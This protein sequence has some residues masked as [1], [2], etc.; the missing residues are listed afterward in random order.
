MIGH[1]VKM[2]ISGSEIEFFTFSDSNSNAVFDLS[3]I[4]LSPGKYI[5]TFTDQNYSRSIKI[6]DN[7][8]LSIP[9]QEIVSVIYL[10]FFQFIEAIVR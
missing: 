2:N 4:N 9:G 6:N 3:G 1:K 5:A 10:K 8:E 7:Y